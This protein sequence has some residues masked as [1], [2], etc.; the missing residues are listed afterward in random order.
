MENMR[1]EEK[2]EPTPSD[3]RAHIEAIRQAMHS[4]G[5]ISDE[6][7]MLNVLSTQ[8]ES[9]QLPP[10]EVIARVDQMEASRNAR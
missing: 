7:D 6:D 5:N 4:W 3:A 8:L 2:A 1:I 10:A 9:G